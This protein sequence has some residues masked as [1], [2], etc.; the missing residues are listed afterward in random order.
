VRTPGLNDQSSQGKY[1]VGYLDAN[2]GKSISR[3]DVAAFM[4]DVLMNDKYIGQMPLISN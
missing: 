4:L 3:P 2:T 1:R